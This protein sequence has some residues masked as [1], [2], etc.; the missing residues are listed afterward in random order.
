MNTIGMTFSAANCDLS[1]SDISGNVINDLEFFAG[2]NDHHGTISGT[3]FNHS[4]LHPLVSG[5]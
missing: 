2:P 5:Y 4:F 3:T 1:D